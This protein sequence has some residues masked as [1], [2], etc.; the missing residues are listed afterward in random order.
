MRISDWSSDVCSSD[1]TALPEALV[2]RIAEIAEGRDIGPFSHHDAVELR[3]VFR[4]VDDDPRL[5]GRAPVGNDLPAAVPAEFADGPEAL[6]GAGDE[7]FL[8]DIAVR[9]HVAMEGTIDRSASA[10]R[11]S[12]SLNSS[13]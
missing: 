4:P 2:H 10:D 3:G 9:R 7:I 6:C 1:L 8:L 11:K 13:H 5:V 12:T